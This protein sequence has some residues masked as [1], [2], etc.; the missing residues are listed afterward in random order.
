MDSVSL[1]AAEIIPYTNFKQMIRVVK[2]ELAK[3]RYV[4]I[5]KDF[6]YSAEKWPC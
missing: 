1:N 6:I 2:R 5:W 4:E 3:N